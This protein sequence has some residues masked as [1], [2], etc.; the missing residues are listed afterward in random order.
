MKGTAPPL[1]AVNASLTVTNFL[2]L[3]KEQLGGG[4]SR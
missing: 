1:E 2:R 3:E 4:E